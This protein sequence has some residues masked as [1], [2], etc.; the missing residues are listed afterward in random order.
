MCV[1]DELGRHV[2][3]YMYTAQLYSSDSS[4]VPHHAAA[5]LSFFRLA[6][7]VWLAA[8]GA[9]SKSLGGKASTDTL[10][11]ALICIQA[12]HRARPHSSH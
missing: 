12:Y 7:S 5:H 10:A 1:A 2:C 4:R 8:L 9:Y 11:P 3:V 6:V